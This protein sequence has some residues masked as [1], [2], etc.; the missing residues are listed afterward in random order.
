LVFCSLEGRLKKLQDHCATWKQRVQ[1]IALVGGR[2]F[3]E[4]WSEIVDAEDE[5]HSTQLMLCH[6]DEAFLIVFPAWVCLVI[7]SVGSWGHVDCRPA[8]IVPVRTS[9]S[10]SFAQSVDT[11]Y[12]PSHSLSN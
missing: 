2:L 4:N 10:D 3:L 7:V 12:G 1:L 5:D 11:A 9:C 8:V 6:A